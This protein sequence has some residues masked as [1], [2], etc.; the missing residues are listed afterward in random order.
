ME[1][2]KNQRQ[3]HPDPDG[4]PNRRENMSRGRYER[5]E[6]PAAGYGPGHTP[7]GDHDQGS[8]SVQSK[9]PVTNHDEQKKATNSGNSDEVMGEQETEGDQRRKER[10]RSYKTTVDDLKNFERKT[11]AME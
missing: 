10:F 9:K 7:S 3:P 4:K 2:N 1:R 5:R 6:E 8:P 11:P